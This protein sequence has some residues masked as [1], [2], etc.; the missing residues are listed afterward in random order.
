MLISRGE[1][2]EIGDGFRIPDILTRSGARLVEVGTTNRTS[3]DD[4]RRAITDR[5]RAILRVHQSNFRM[6]GFTARPSLEE[7]A[8]LAGGDIA[9]IDDLGSGALLDLPEMLDEPTAAAA[10]TAGA[11]LV[12]FSGDKLLGGP[13][14]GIVVGTGRAVE[15]VKRHP[16]ARALRID[17]LSLAALEA[18]LELYRDPAT[19]LAQVPVLRM[20]TEPAEAV[21]ARAQRLCE[22]LGGRLTETHRARGRRRAAAARAAQLCV[23]AGRRRGAGGAVAGGQPAGG[24]PRPGGAGAA[25]L[26]HARRGRHRSHPRVSGAPP[27]TLGTAG[28]IDHGKTALVAALTGVDTD[29]LPQEKSRGISIELGYAPLLLPSGRRLSVVDVPGHERFVRTMLAGATG[30]D[31][32]VLAVAC[33]DGV[34]PQTREH[35][36]IL[37]MLGLERG[38]VALTKRDLV[39]HETAALARLTVEEL[40]P[41]VPVLEV[42]ARTGAGIE[43]LR[44]QLDALAAGVAA[45][46]GDGPVRLPVDRAFTLRGIGTVVTGT[47]WSGTVRPNDRLAIEPERRRG[48]RAKRA[49][50]RRRGRRGGRRPAGG[51]GA[52]RRRATAGAPRRHAVDAGHAA[53]KLPARVRAGGA[54]RR[55][56]TAAKRPAADRSPCHRRDARACGRARGRRDRTGTARPRAAAAGPAGG[57]RRG[58]PC[59]AA[60]DRAAGDHGRRHRARS[61]THPKRSSAAASGDRRRAAPAR[62]LSAEGAD[63][64]EQR[65]AE[66]PFAP[67]P[68]Q[69]AD[70]APAAYLADAGRIVRA[71]RDLAFTTAAYEQARDAAVEIASAGGTVTIAQLRDRLGCSRRYAQALLEAMDGHGITR[72]V[73]DERVLRRRARGEG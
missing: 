55:R 30:I 4:Y 37:R 13:Q 51:A 61:G 18:T 28:H 72:R 27:L 52:D 22:R 33:D 43:Q 31:L 32:W 24:R 6:V 20:A 66:Q 17:K 14:A 58:R 12:C 42:S 48:P 9:L 21:R 73:G 67:P 40:L 54:G 62:T 47:L 8:E 25:R 46:S 19:A 1:L 50:A 65:L 44:A 69:A 34:M 41:D 59:G 11:D 49:G 29:R 10:V 63:E 64:L 5:T 3:L 39:D 57:G 2:I 7:L 56:S 38:V 26:P 23:C 60:H 71:G 68:L 35:V 45:R 53:P 70:Q 36:A 15:R 16:L